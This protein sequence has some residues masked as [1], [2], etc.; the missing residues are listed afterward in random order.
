MPIPVVTVSPFQHPSSELNLLPADELIKTSPLDQAA[1]AHQG[2]LGA[3]QRRRFQM[4]TRLLPRRY[5]RLLEVGYGSGIF[6]P[7][8]NDYTSH[9]DG[10]D[11]HDRPDDVASVLAQRGVEADLVTASVEDLPY[12]DESFDAIVSVSALEFVDDLPAAVSE[13]ARVLRKDGD[14]V[15]VTPGSSRLLDWGLKLLTGERAEDTFCGRRQ[16]IIPALTASFSIEQVKLFPPR[17]PEAVRLYTGLRLR[18]R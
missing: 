16:Q 14:L 2:V 13:L 3:I 4:V 1:W 12:G 11:V 15:V 6:M 9:L 5:P 10:A 18:R 17:L 7:T 8:L